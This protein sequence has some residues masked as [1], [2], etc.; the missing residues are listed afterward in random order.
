MYQPCLKRT[1]WQCKWTIFLTA[2]S[3]PDFISAVFHVTHVHWLTQNNGSQSEL[4]HFY[5]IWFDFGSFC[6]F[7]WSLFNPCFGFLIQTSITWKEGVSNY[8]SLSLM[9]SGNGHFRIKTLYMAPTNSQNMYYC[10]CLNNEFNISI[11][12]LGSLKLFC[13]KTMGIYYF[14]FNGSQAA[15]CL[16]TTCTKIWR[17]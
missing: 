3:L 16:K 6:T 7:D 2:V 8:V 4:C 5:L 11:V 1:S 17:S 9:S 13:A 14:T 12:A 15:Q 10:I